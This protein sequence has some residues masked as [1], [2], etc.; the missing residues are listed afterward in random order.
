MVKWGYEE[1]FRYYK[2]LNGK[3]R[4]ANTYGDYVYVLSLHTLIVFF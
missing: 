1:S 2:V 3:F 4:D